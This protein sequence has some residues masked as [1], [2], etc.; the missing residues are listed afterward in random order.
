MYN[1]I[2]WGQLEYKHILD[3]SSSLCKGSDLRVT[4]VLVLQMLLLQQ[5]HYITTEFPPFA[6]P[7][8]QDCTHFGTFVGRKAEESGIHQ[9]Q[10]LRVQIPAGSRG[11]FPSLKPISEC[12]CCTYLFRFFSFIIN[13]K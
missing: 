12:Y 1:C 2:L 7:R 9:T 8:K 4:R 3:S 10:N 11:F 5:E 6:S 13:V